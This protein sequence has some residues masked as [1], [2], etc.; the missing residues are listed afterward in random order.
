MLAWLRGAAAGWDT[1]DTPRQH[2]HAFGWLVFAFVFTSAVVVIGVLRWE[3]PPLYLLLPAAAVIPGVIQQ[4]RRHLRHR[5]EPEQLHPH[6]PTD[7][8]R[9]PWQHPT[10]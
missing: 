6:Q 10:R 8:D 5:A 1:A 3:L 4:R 9:D 2:R 7:T